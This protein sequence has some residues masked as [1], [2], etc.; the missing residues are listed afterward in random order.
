MRARGKK[1]KLVSRWQGQ[2]QDVG[3]E[4]Q[5][6]AGGIGGGEVG[7]TSTTAASRGHS[8]TP[9][10]SDLF[11]SLARARKTNSNNRMLRMT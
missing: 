10:G 5:K 1:S 4:G 9:K 11:G 2:R 6:V 7:S 8:A 3:A